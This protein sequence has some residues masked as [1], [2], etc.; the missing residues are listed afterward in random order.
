MPCKESTEK[1]LTT[2]LWN[3]QFGLFATRDSAQGV[4]AKSHEEKPKNKEEPL[5]ISCTGQK[6]HFVHAVIAEVR[7]KKDIH[8]PLSKS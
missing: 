5:Y 6:V 3:S 7:A 1:Y 2:I 8:N 4:S